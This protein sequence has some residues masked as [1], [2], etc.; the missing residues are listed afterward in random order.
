MRKVD[1][2]FFNKYTVRHILMNKLGN[3]SNTHSIP[4]ISKLLFTFS[5]DR[6]DDID[7]ARV[8]NYIYLFKFFFGKIA[9]STK[10][11][12]YYI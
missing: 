5:L 11:K 8:Y 6:I 9:Y 2:N 1:Y 4:R 7:S 12:S 10:L 3:I